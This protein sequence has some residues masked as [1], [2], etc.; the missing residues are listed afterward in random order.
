ML[1]TRFSLNNPVA[2][3]LF[4]ALVGI[5][6]VIAFER[7]GRSILPPVGFPV[8]SVQAQYPGAAPAE[9]E[10]LVVA[11]IEAQARSLPNVERIWSSAEDGVAGIQLRFQFGSNIETD[12]A[13]AQQA[14]DA[15]RA[16]LPPDLVAPTLTTQDPS[17]APVLE[18]SITSAVLSPRALTDLVE[19]EIAPAL[20]ASPG[21]GMVAISGEVRRQLTVAPRP[22]ALDAVGI[23]PLDLVRAV[24]SAGDVFPGGRLR[25]TREEST[26]GVRSSADTVSALRALP[27]APPNGSSVRVGDVAAVEDASVP[28]TELITVDGEPAILLEISRASNASSLRTIAKLTRTFDRLA[29]QYPLIRF[30]MLRS[31]APY[32]IAATDGVFQTIGEGIALTVLVMLLF[33]RSWRNAV[34]ASI[35]IPTSLC[36]ALIAM[37]LAG[38]T[39]NV[40]S[41][42]GLSLTIGILVDDSIVIVEAIAAAAARGMRP[43][44]AAL[45]GRNEL[46]PAAFAITLVDVAVFAPIAFMTGVVGQFMREFG[47]MIVFA[48]AFS[49]LVALTLTP[50]LAAH[51]A[52][53]ER[54]LR[55]IGTLPWM[56]RTAAARRCGAAL[57]AAR[58][59][60]LE[61]EDGLARR[62]A[63]RWLPGA[64]RHRGW[65]IAAAALACVTA[66]WLLVSGRISTE[67][68][69]P[70]DAGKASVA[71][72]FP[73]GTPLRVSQARASRIAEALLDDG[74]IRHVVVRSGE[75]F[76]GNTNV[77]ASNLAQIDALLDDQSASADPIVDRI[78]QLQG[79]VADAAITGAGRGMGGT[80]PVTYSIAGDSG[81]IDVAAERIAAALRANPLATD[82]RISSAGV[83]PRIDVA[84]D[85]AKTELLHVAQDDAAQTA[86][87][88]TGGALAAR[89]RTG[90]GI[91]DV[92]VQSEAAAR[93]DL[94]EAL[95]LSVRSADS[96]TIPLADLSTVTRTAEPRIIEREDGRRIVTV[97]ANTVGSAPIGLVSGPITKALRTPEF[98]PAGARVEARGDVEQF[99]ETAERIVATLALS[100]VIVYVILAILYR[101]YALPLV[102]MLTVPLAAIG[103][104]GALFLTR[105]PV[106]LYS[107]LG[108]VMLT[109]LVAKNGILLV[110]YAEREWRRGQAASAAMLDAARRRFRPIV[111]TTL[112][113]VSGM[114]PLA[115]GHTIGAQYRQALGIVVIGGLSSSLLLTLFIVPVAYVSY[116]GKRASRPVHRTSPPI[117]KINASA[118]MTFAADANESPTTPKGEALPLA[119]ITPAKSTPKRLSP[120][121]SPEATRMPSCLAA[122]GCGWVAAQR[123]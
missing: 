84:V 45:A 79:L 7:I 30:T 122:P 18:E 109:G 73:A 3:T 1:L 11:P 70:V 48:T 20:R 14:V 65:A 63:Q 62:Y 36:A 34:I 52:L 71:L 78:K 81:A 60:W 77:V 54:S 38:F 9:I 120:T 83:G 15:A 42:M 96:R 106:N 13:D 107:M 59:R 57:R 85:P 105:A 82:V 37:W 44:S 53:R 104:F 123:L 110:E 117:I 116:R 21:V 25:S 43:D 27:V 51:W 100:M 49:L 94:D 121:M 113:M 56:L 10:R 23:T 32:T 69:P 88:A 64:L 97:T 101:S 8:V 72:T 74:R 67:F 118:P 4:F 31:D 19:N 47:L 80:A 35:A 28:P 98:L 102:I 76:S 90:S 26:I 91:T 24:A 99:L 103:A 5:L 12:R 93:G 40:L 50:L 17:Q 115:L 66:L 2:V 29:Q 16:N 22:G 111:M 92:F 86:R 61:C 89:V 39:I 108:I 68:S 119:T 114:L 33:L 87:I 58:D 75:S 46:G 6:G 41:L 112:A 55:K 95:R